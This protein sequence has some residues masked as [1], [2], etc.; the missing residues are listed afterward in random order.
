MSKDRII[1]LS[2]IL[3]GE[4]DLIIK[5]LNKQGSKLTLF[6][7]SALKSQKRFGGG[8]L[9]PFNFIEVIFSDA[10]IR[11]GYPSEMHLLTEAKLLYDFPKLRLDWSKLELGYYFLKLT[12]KLSYH[13]MLDMDGLFDLLGNTLKNLEVTQSLEKLKLHFEI[14]L[15]AL[16]GV[17]PTYPHA[18]CF[19]TKN[20]ADH[21]QIIIPRD[22]EDDLRK[23]ITS[24]MNE[25]L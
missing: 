23:N 12:D 21:A 17:L 13:E 8:V 10:R 24:S 2:K 1:V 11:K 18:E 25:L 20:V 14:K 7:K 19:S 16:L 5:G 15:L 4:S 9:D 22:K 6:A 3:F